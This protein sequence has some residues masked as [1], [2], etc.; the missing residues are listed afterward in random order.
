MSEESYSKGLEGVVTAES[1]ICKVDGTGGHL[2]Y[3]GYSIEDLARESSFEEVVY[4]LLYEKLPDRNEM[5]EFRARMRGARSLVPEIQAMIRAYPQTASAME[6][7][8]SVISYLSGY[9][10]HTIHH[11][12]KCNCRRTLHQIAQ[13]PTV[14]ACRYRFGNGLDYVEPRDDLSH[15]ANFLYMMHGEEP[16]PEVGRMMDTCLLMHAEHG[17]NASTFTARVVA[18][19]YSTCYCGISAAVGALNGFL[20]G[21]A[22]EGVLSMLEEIGGVDNVEAWLDK[23]LAEK[24]RVMGMGHRVYKVKDPRAVIM[25]GFLKALSEKRNDSHHIELLKAIEAAFAERMKEKGK[26]IYP[27]VDFFTGSVYTLMGIPKAFFTPIFAMARAAG[28]LGHILEQRK[29][30]RLYR[31]TC[32]YTGPEPRPYVPIESRE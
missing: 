15:G 14:L 8:Q 23:A 2:Y 31:P 20:H 4:L 18:S 19:T 6:L 1:E 30:N 12:D 29:D 7:L 16:D 28:W 3:R 9:V 22:N 10:E 11:S 26:P 13:L 32:I 27:N 17:F 25:E 21:G 5:D 24:R